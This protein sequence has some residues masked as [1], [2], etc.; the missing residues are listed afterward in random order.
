MQQRLTSC[1]PLHSSNVGV[2]CG[3]RRGQVRPGCRCRPYRVVY[4]V[5]LVCS[6]LVVLC[7]GCLGRSYLLQELLLLEFSSATQL[8]FL[9][10]TLVVRG[11]PCGPK[12]GQQARGP[13]HGH[14]ATRV[15]N[16]VKS[17]ARLT[18]TRTS[19]TAQG[20]AVSMAQ[21]LQ[22]HNLKVTHDNTSF[23]SYH[24]VYTHTGT[25][26]RGTHCDTPEPSH[27]AL[28]TRT[29]GML[30]KRAN[31][32]AF[33]AASNTKLF[34]NTCVTGGRGRTRASPYRRHT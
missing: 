19:R 6:F 22:C 21:S 15:V 10:A 14:G 3:C 4:I 9:F 30:A 7:V 24:P 16:Q 27:H 34:T 2:F 32:A 26:R 33:K 25:A 23:G 13:A 11:R 8:R 12:Q 28:T 18:S 31:R 1:S 5:S 20:R 17:H 29:D